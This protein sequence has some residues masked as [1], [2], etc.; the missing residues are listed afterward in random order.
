MRLVLNSTVI[1]NFTLVG[2]IEWLY[3]LWPNELVTTEQAMAEL[4][5]VRLGRIP[6]VDLSCLTSVSLTKL[7]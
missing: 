6:E 3:N 7:E 1:S 4:Q 5:G 2:R